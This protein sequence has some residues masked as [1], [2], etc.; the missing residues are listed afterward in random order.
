MSLVNPLPSCSNLKVKVS[1]LTKVT[2]LSIVITAPLKSS[3]LPIPD[4]P[5]VTVIP[6]DIAWLTS[7]K[8]IDLELLTAAFVTP[9]VN[10]FNI[11]L[12]PCLPTTCIVLTSPLVGIVSV[13]ICNSVISSGLS[14]KALPALAVIRSLS[15]IGLFVLKT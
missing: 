1:P 4:P 14:K 11:N 6:E 8:V 12:A 10:S 2:F 13:D 15:S 5:L 7:V 9:V 3:T